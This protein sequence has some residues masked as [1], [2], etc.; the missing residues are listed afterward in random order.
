MAHSL[1]FLTRSQEAYDGRLQR[2]ASYEDRYNATQAGLCSLRYVIHSEMP[3]NEGRMVEMDSDSRDHADNM[4]QHIIKT[5][6]ATSAAVRRVNRDGSLTGAL[7]I[8][9]EFDDA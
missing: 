2:R 5:W 1:E 9:Y 8:H 4:A 7:A 6:G 3:Q